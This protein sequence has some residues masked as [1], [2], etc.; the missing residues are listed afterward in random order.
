MRIERVELKNIKP[1]AERAFDF[2][3]GVNVLCGMNGAGKSTVFEAIGYALFGVQPQSFIGR[4]DR[5]VRKGH[6]RGEV[7]VHF[8]LDDGSRYVVER[9]AGSSSRWQLFRWISGTL[10][11]VD[12]KNGEELES[13]LKR[14]LGLN[15]DQPL[16]DQFLHVIGPLQSDFFGPFVR[17]GRARADEFE[18]ILGIESWREA[19]G[20]SR[21]V[22]RVA[23]S[24]IERC[25]DRVETLRAQTVRL[26]DVETEILE[27]RERIE[28]TRTE[29]EVASAERDIAE[30]K[31]ALLERAGVTLRANEQRVADRRGALDL[32]ETKATRVAA[33]LDK[34]R[35]SERICGDRL[36]DH[37]AFVSCETELKRLRARQREAAEIG[38]RLAR[39][40][41]QY[42]KLESTER[43]TREAAMRRLVTLEAQREAAADAVSHHGEE[44][45]RR[46]AHARDAAD[47]YEAAAAWRDRLEPLR[48]AS[49]LRPLLDDRWGQLAEASR[50]VDALT[51]RL[52]RRDA[53]AAAAAAEPALLERQTEIT[54]DLARLGAER[55]HLES[56]ARS[57]ATG[58]CPLLS[59][60]CM[61]IG[62]RDPDEF[63]GERILTV[64]AALETVR[65]SASAIDGQLAAARVAR[66][67]LDLVSQQA[68]RLETEA[69]RLERLRAEIAAAERELTSDVVL[70]PLAS[71]AA[72]CPES[73][74]RDSLTAALAE[75]SV[76]LSTQSP[77][78]C[79]PLEQLEEALSRRAVETCERLRREREEIAAASTAVAARLDGSR[80]ELARVETETAVA[81]AEI[82]RAD[83][84]ARQLVEVGAERFELRSRK[85]EFAGLDETI[86]DFEQRLETARAGHDLYAAHANEAGRVDGYARELDD[87]VIER[88]AAAAALEEATAALD[89]A[90]RDF[91][92]D[93]YER[94]KSERSDLLLR[95]GALG[96]SLRSSAE[97]IE[98]R[99]A[100]RREL[101]E[102]RRRIVEIEAESAGYE[103]TLDL[104]RS[105]R[106]DVFNRVGGRLS[107]RYRADISV[108]ADRIYRRIAHTD[109]ELRWGDGFRVELVDYGADD[110]GRTVERVRYDEELSGGQRM[111]AVVALRLAL[112]Q[113]TGATVGFFDEPTSNLDAARRA[114]LAEAFRAL[115]ENRDGDGRRWYTQLFLVSHDVAFSEI[116]DHTTNLD[117]PVKSR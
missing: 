12:T 34:A 91:D 73:D 60:Q 61:N 71:W 95:I 48:R 44:L 68:A 19:Y 36:A 78:A 21:E 80:R 59:E 76:E 89:L 116:T 67:E 104:I 26:P 106:A 45:G 17:K 35:V 30:V 13:E 92:P 28:R 33:L 29:L 58:A 94:I 4:A 82:A 97:A 31:F 54:R 102:I 108:R 105:L 52:A 2:A 112:L 9:H 74:T 72:E 85:G 18:R 47:R 40:E 81:H 39:I 111:S 109:E 66:E 1:F 20:K 10:D 114:R 87:L 62:D 117:L 55:G 115:D 53:L 110:K 70:P 113:A 56:S 100:E 50:A 27:A 99:E 84:L 88:T 7:R 98:R 5:F 23:E 43:E 41:T 8:A 15:L 25:R 83:D 24:R 42:A 11:V 65:E 103:R 51:P 90:R 14:L 96:D 86:R 38:D 49:R 16:A 22:E 93:A 32:V 37:Q 75:Y 77:D 101:L 57:L 69:L 46:G 79:E 107:E 63:F 6:R 3:D 64:D